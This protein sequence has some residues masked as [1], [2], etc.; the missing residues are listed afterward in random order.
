[1]TTLTDPAVRYPFLADDALDI[2]PA[3]FALHEQGPIPV[4]LP[5]GPP[6]WLA[7]RYADVRTVFVDR[8]FSRMLPPGEPP[9]VS[10]APQM[11]DPSYPLGMDPPDHTRLRR[12]TSPVFSPRS[13]R[14]MSER[15]QHH[16]DELLDRVLDTGPGADLVA[17]LTWDLAIMSLAD[18]M[19][20]PLADA[21]RF[22][23]WVETSTDYHAE[24][25]E[26]AEAFGAINVYV[27]EQIARRRA[28]HHD[29]LLGLLVEAHDEGDRLST[30]ELRS[31]C[32]S[33]VV[34]GF[35]TTATQLGNTVFTLMTHRD[36]WDE[37][38]DGR[39]E[40]RP[41]TEEL[42][43]WIPSFR[44]GTPFV[45]WAKEDVELSGGV[46][47]RKGEAVVPEQALANR[48]EAAFPHAQEIDF[49]RV[50]PLPHLGLGFGEHL[51]MGL[52]LAK[53]QV[54]LTVATLARRFP[55]LELAVAPSELGWPD[56]FFLR[57]LDTLPVTW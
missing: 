24:P 31:V 43:R 55:G 57:T 46:V 21:Q 56:W 8:R 33:L 23:G 22:R 32:L 20:V 54:D 29:D 53:L 3:Y 10:T 51:C 16:V 42:W 38:V 17:L 37:L 26:V 14:A 34:G 39:A 15:I 5:Y 13:I 52:H 7:S 27:D 9:G 49:H 12:I 19:G 6:C 4:Q 2:D 45:R 50:D 48:D 1:M 36:R 40:L 18:M 44:Y 30:P 28:E 11:I 35:E 25:A 41:A 47:V